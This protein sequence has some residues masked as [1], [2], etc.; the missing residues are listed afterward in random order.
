MSVLYCILFLFASPRNASINQEPPTVYW[1]E[2]RPLTYE[3]FTG[4]KPV[5]ATHAGQISNDVYVMPV[6]NSQKRGYSFNVTAIAFKGGSFLISSSPRLL[7]HEQLHFDIAELLARMIRKNYSGR[8]ISESTLKSIQEEID[9]YKT[10]EL[11]RMHE[12]YDSI[13]SHGS[14]REK[15][16]EYETIIRNQLKALSAFKD[17]TF[18]E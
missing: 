16:L 1:C 12:V 15:Q 5:G 11:V 10:S 14:L 2:N 9:A 18:C 3:D 6:Y 4:R 7:A 13:T 17:A 8:T